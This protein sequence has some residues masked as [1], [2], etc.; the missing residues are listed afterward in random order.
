MSGRT[1][2]PHANRDTEQF[3]A[4]FCRRATCYPHGIDKEC[5]RKPVL[6]S[7]AG[8]IVSAAVGLLITAVAVMPSHAQDA[9]RQKGD[10]ACKGDAVK[11]CK[12]VLGQGDMIVLSCFQAN[13]ARLS[14]S[15]RSFL[16]SVNQLD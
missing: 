15:C 7:R 2:T 8:S 1:D 3:A 13:K 5:R 16:K 4:A 6:V 10:A 11:L 12:D 9:M 14:G